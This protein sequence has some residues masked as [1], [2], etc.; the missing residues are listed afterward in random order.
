MVK[1]GIVFL[2]SLFLLAACGGEDTTD[3]ELESNSEDLV[4]EPE[5]EAESE[6]ETETESEADAEEEI[7]VAETS[8]VAHT[9]D[10]LVNEATFTNDYGLQAWDDYQAVMQDI[11][12]GEITDIL[13]QEN[14]PAAEVTGTSKGELEELF[15][16]VDLREDVFQEEAEVN[17]AEDLVFYR[18]PPAED[19]DYNDVA[20]FLAEMTF[21]FYDDNMMF[22]AITPGFY[23]VEFND[24]PSAED[25]MLFVSVDEIKEL[26]P[27]IFTVA[28]MQVDGER[29]QQVMTPA[30]ATDEEGNDLLAAFYFFTH[31]EDILQYA[32]LPFEMVSQDFPTGSILVFQEIV[33]E[34]EKLEL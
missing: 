12:L 27:Q 25:L 19:S 34:L 15:N 3:T 32:F 13:N 23:S 16:S 24:V 31:G 26:N 30:M 22:S 17:E 4:S 11:E 21:H 20:L 8:N 5:V 2:S 18:Y 9:Y 7:E 1:K 14:P 10:G 6:A 28:E 33:P 29:I